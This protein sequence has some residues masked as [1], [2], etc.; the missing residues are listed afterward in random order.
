MVISISALNLTDD[1]VKTTGSLADIISVVLEIAKYV[2]DI[3]M[4]VMKII[5]CVVKITTCC[6][7]HKFGCC[8]DDR[9]IFGNLYLCYGHHILWCGFLVTKLGKIVILGALLGHF[10]N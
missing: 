2:L 7:H 6:E 8:E 3:T 9:A 10:P 5:N 1:V 4:Y